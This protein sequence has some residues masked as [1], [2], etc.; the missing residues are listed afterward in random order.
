VFLDDYARECVDFRHLLD[1]S[2]EKVEEMRGFA[3]TS[4]CIEFMFF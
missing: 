2:G 4:E 1:E 3:M